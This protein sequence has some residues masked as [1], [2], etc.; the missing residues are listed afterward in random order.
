MALPLPCL[1]CRSR[2]GGHI[3]NTLLFF[4]IK[5]FRPRRDGLS[6]PPRRLC[7]RD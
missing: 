1:T 4:G 5:S 3:I 7:A 6:A 2:R